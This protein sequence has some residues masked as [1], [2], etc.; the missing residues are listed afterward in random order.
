MKKLKRRADYFNS[1]DFIYKDDPLALDDCNSLANALVPRTGEEKGDGMHFLDVAEMHISAMAAATVQY[2]E[3]NTRSLQKV[4]ELLAHPQQL[5]M[6][7]KLM[8]ESDAWG[9]ML[10]TMG[11]QLTHF[12][13]KEKGS[14]LTT[15]A[16]FL[17]FLGTPA[18]AESTSRSTFDPADLRRGKMTVYLVLP[19]EH[20]RAQSPLLRM[21]IGSL[22]RAVVRGGLQEKNKVHFVLDEAASLGHLEALDD[23]VD[24]YRGYGVR[25]QFYYQSLGQLKKCWPADQGQTLLSNTTKI[26]FGCNV[27]QEAE[28]WSK[29][30]GN[31]TIVVDSGG[32]STSWGQ[33]RGSSSG[34]SHSQSTGSN[35][36]G[37]S[38]SNWQ[39]QSRELLKPDE[40]IAL[41]PRIAITLTPGLRP[42][43]TRL[44][45]YYEEPG[46]FRA[47]GWFTRLAAAGWTL[48]I[49]AA[50]LAT[51]IAGAAA[52]TIQLREAIEHQ[53][54][55]QVAPAASQPPPR[56][57]PR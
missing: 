6:A 14:T 3:Q 44:V 37:G 56:L 47:R 34:Q 54:K 28:F 31:E 45:R 53:Q 55:Q 15:C 41:D 30:L 32:T 35:W 9:G 27:I 49:S 10:A 2:G 8:R 33:N 11:A 12:V 42:L 1:L 13:D 26:M 19:P 17:R 39:Q 24:K 5:E 16:R 48:L 21:W 46:L 4:R 20:L 50:L 52:V 29:S 36:G 57:I 18:V 23:A 40:I 22:L 7:I 43:W 51:A 25:L 38:T